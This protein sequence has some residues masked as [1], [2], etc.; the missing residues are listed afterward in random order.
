MN[1]VNNWITNKVS[2]YELLCGDFNDDP[3]FNGASIL[4]SE[5]LDRCSSV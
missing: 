5:A 3:I 1:A 2:D 4:N